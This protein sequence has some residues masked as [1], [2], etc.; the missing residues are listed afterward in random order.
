MDAYLTKDVRQFLDALNLMDSKSDGFLIGHKRG[1][2]LFVEK[3][4]ATHTNFFPSLEKVIALDNLFDK[5]I[6]GFFSFDPDE[7]KVKKILTPFAYGKLYLEIRT[8]GH[9]TLEIAPYIID[10]DETFVLKKIKLKN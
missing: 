10:H 1:H 4:L 2:R 8:Q 9:K 3:L 6:I 5:K 7:K